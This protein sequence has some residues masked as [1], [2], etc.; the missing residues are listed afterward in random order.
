MWK[1]IQILVFGHAHEWEIKDK[2]SLYG[3]DPDIPIGRRYYI[4][5]KHCCEMKVKDL[6]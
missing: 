3:S 1:L 2:V 6:H 4:K 5:C